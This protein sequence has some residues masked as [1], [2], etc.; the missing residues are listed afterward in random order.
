M[1]SL[2]SFFL[3]YHTKYVCMYILDSTWFSNVYLSYFS[4]DFKYEDKSSIGINMRIFG[5]KFKDRRKKRIL[6]KECYL[7]ARGPA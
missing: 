4:Y 3:S 6:A 1:I 7:H 5:K 2:P